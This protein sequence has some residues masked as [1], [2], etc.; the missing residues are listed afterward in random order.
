MTRRWKRK[1]LLNSDGPSDR[2]RGFNKGQAGERD[3]AGE[4]QGGRRSSWLDDAG[5]PTHPWAVGR[6]WRSGEVPE[7]A[8]VKEQESVSM[9]RRIP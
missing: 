7:T 3:E 9:G 4:G 8:A 1:R 5:L 6:G 2:T